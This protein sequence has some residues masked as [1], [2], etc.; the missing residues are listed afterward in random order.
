MNTILTAILKTAFAYVLLFTVIRLLGRKAVSQMTF[1]DLT[2]IITLGSVTANLAIGRE[3]TV[4]QVTTILLT[5]AFLAITTDYLNTKSL[6][7]RKLTNSEPVT[8]I[9]NGKIIEQNLKKVRF[10]INQLNSML[11]EKNIFDIGDVEFA[12][13]EN[14]GQL[15]V[16]PKSQKQPLTPADLKIPT[17]YKGLTSDIIIDGR[18]MRDNLIINNLDN[19]WLRNQLKTQGIENPQEVFYAGLDTAGNLYVSK[20]IKRMEKEGQYRIE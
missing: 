10:T 4:I 5:L 1:Y 17:A 8:A 15:S 7:F 11:R 2:V 3:N 19:A 9:A 18:I 16:L 14:E 6:W 20:R 13:I 12:I